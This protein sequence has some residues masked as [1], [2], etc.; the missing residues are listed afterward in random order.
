MQLIQTAPGCKYSIVARV[1]TTI[2]S[3]DQTWTLDV[4]SGQSDFIAETNETIIPA[5]AM[6]C[7]KQHQTEEA[8][9]RVNLLG[10][11]AGSMATFIA[12]SIEQI[13]GK[14][15]AKVEYG[16]GKLTVAVGLDTTESQLADVKTLLDR[17]LPR[18]L[19]TEIEYYKRVDWLYARRT[20]G[21]IETD[22][23]AADDVGVELEV[24]RLEKLDSYLCGADN[25]TIGESVL[26]LRYVPGLGRT[27]GCWGKKLY[28]KNIP[29]ENPYEK[30]L[31]QINFLNS[32][33]LMVTNEHFTHEVTVSEKLSASADWGNYLLFS[34]G[35]KTNSYRGGARIYY[36]TFSKGEEIIAHYV[37]A[38]DPTGAPCMFDTV[39]RTPFYNSGAGDFLYPTDAAPAA[40][41]GLDDKFYAKLTEHGV[42]RLYHVPEGCTMTKDDY[43]AANGFKELVEPPMPLEGYW[44]PQWRE[45]DTQLVCDWI[46]TEPPTEVTENV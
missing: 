22:V 45:T 6:I 23:Q 9:A 26:A 30:T 13:V 29:D 41:I 34:T 36:A 42:R 5:D 28:Y 43:A 15:N 40:A 24:E 11:G 35:S 7:Q 10:E 2:Y 25:A 19:V 44:M 32:R 27:R 33:R 31:K 37:P 18:N 17:V 1:D 46:E 3:P 12:R 21:I 16:D 38:L 39:T 4:P 8:L 14:G 20:G